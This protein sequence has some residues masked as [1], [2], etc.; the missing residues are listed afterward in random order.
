LHIGTENLVV[1]ETPAG[2]RDSLEPGDYVA[3]TVSDS[4]IGMSREVIE[5]AFDPFFTTKPAGQGTGLGLSM[6]YGFAQQSGGKVGIASAPGQG[7]A[8]TI[9]LPRASPV[10]ADT[11]PA[12]G[13][14]PLGSG[15]TVMVVEDVAA[16]RML[17]IDVLHELGY[18]TIEAAD[19]AEALPLIDSSAAID[20]LVSDVGLPGVGGRQLADYAR[21]RRPGLKVLFVTGYA[22]HA[23]TRS[24]FLDEGMALITKPFAV[25]TLATKVSEIMAAQ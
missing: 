7:T 17:I 23:T 14:A 4:G 8:V 19:A 22:E 2:G 10:A 21:K 1:G 24:G 15:E 16:V 20:L 25:E 18:R 9:T 13:V 5:K 11:A 6:V 3:V 12:Q